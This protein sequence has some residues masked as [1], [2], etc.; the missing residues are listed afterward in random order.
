MARSA[1][2][3][4]VSVQVVALAGRL[5]GASPLSARQ[6]ERLAEGKGV[7]REVESEGSPRQTTSLTNRNR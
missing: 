7:H 3:G 5:G 1:V 6:G 2:T 4:A